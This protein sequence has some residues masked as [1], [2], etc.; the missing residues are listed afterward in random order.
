M[1]ARLENPKPLSNRSFVI[2]DMFKTVACVNRVLR[3]IGKRQSRTVVAWIIEVY[4]DATTARRSCRLCS[5]SDQRKSL[6]R[7]EPPKSRGPPSMSRSRRRKASVRSEGKAKPVQERI[8]HGNDRR[9]HPITEATVVTRRKDPRA[10]RA[11]TLPGQGVPRIIENS[12]SD[13]RTFAFVALGQ[14]G[15]MKS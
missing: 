14:I 5:T 3:L 6:Q 11:S 15:P 8:A 10:R 2:A 12:D 1:S 9:S 7:L 13:R 4:A